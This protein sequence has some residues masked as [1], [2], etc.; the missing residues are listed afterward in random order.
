MCCPT[1]EW[2]QH[3]PANF[4]NVG[5]G[6]DSETDQGDDGCHPVPWPGI[7]SEKDSWEIVMEKKEGM[8]ERDLNRWRKR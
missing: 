4:S 3:A 1:I 6:L 7:S 8:V 5:Q 2:P